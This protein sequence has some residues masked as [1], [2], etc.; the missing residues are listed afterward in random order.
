MLSR[1]VSPRRLANPYRQLWYL[2]LVYQHSYRV[3]LI[4][5]ILPLHDD[6]DS[7][8]VRVSVVRFVACFEG[9]SGPKSETGNS[10]SSGVCL[11]SCDSEFSRAPVSLRDH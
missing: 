2:Q 6:S 8:L 5:L 11:K 3:K 1:G 7:T 4:V 9:I 10:E